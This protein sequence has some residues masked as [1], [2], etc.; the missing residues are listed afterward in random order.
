MLRRKK[1]LMTGESYSGNTEGTVPVTQISG[2]Q[3]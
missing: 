2:S 1:I 3:I